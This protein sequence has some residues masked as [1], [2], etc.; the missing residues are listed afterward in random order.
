MPYLTY[1]ING[2]NQTFELTANA[3]SIG[4]GAEAQLRLRDNLLSRLHCQFRKAG[5]GY[6]VIDLESRNGTTVN[7]ASAKEAVLR[8][9][10]VIQVGHTR[11][12]YHDGPAPRTPAPASQEPSVPESG[13][14]SQAESARKAGTQRGQATPQ[15]SSEEE[16]AL[17]REFQKSRKDILQELKKVIIGQEEVIEQVLFAML[18]RGHCLLVGVPGLAKTLL[19]SSLASIMD[20]RFRRIQFTPDLMPSDITGTR[21]ME[22]DPQSG[23]RNFRFVKGPL[24]ANIVLA[25]E[26]NRTPPKTQAALLEAMQE[27]RVTVAGITY[28]LDLP[29][30]VLATQNPIE[31]EGTYP[32][33][34]A[35]LDRF[36]FNVRL[37]YPPDSDEVEILMATTTDAGPDLDIVLNEDRILEYQR[38]VRRIPLSDYLVRYVQQLV[39]LTR[40]TH[41]ESPDFV[42]D[43]VNWGAGPRAGQYIILAAKARALYYGRFSVLIEDIKAVLPPVLRHRVA[44]NFNARADGVDSDEIV[45]RLLQKCK[46]PQGG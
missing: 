42:R 35:Q 40:P 12:V 30:L 28:E 14:G 25:D 44:V 15:R 5:D 23:R 6:E 36:M 22:E 1:S 10:D 8:E 3:I 46:E 2:E 43:Y 13:E 9:G 21:I 38:M 26:I 16:L 39:R 27:K 20:L 11:L 37:D 18:A 34:E 29:F 4:R 45:R 7:G 19:V 17:A 31:Q 32:L 33:P 41:P 24:F